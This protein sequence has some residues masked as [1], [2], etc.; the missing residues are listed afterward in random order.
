MYILHLQNKAQTLCGKLSD[1]MGM[2][3]LIFNCLWVNNYFYFGDSTIIL[4]DKQFITCATL[5]ISQ[6]CL[7]ISKA[8]DFFEIV[9]TKEKDSQLVLSHL[10]VGLSSLAQTLTELQKVPAI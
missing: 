10:F 9:R 8:Q 2:V 4:I 3:D 5:I 7:S 1:T 6:H